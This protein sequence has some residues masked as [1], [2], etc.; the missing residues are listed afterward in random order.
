LLESAQGAAYDGYER[1]VDAHIKN[2]RAKI[3]RDPRQP[4]YVETVFGV[5]YRFRK[6]G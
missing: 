2:L 4:Q 1:S 6:D 3:E 5:G